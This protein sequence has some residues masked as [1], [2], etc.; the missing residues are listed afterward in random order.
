MRVNCAS[1][2]H[3]FSSSTQSKRLSCLLDRMLPNTRFTSP[4]NTSLL[5][6][7]LADSLSVRLR[8][9]RWGIH[10]Y[11]SRCLLSTE[12]SCTHLQLEAT[13]PWMTSDC[14]YRRAASALANLFCRADKGHRAEYRRN[15]T[16][17]IGFSTRVIVFHTLHQYEKP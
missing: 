8:S 14:C 10:K 9:S 15:N 2:T 17:G 6:A 1:P 11:Q 4:W 16:R 12:A 3:P 7:I 5:V 13:K